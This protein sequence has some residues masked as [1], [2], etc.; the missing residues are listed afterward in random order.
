MKQEARKS[1]RTENE[2]AYLSGRLQCADLIEISLS[3]PLDYEV[4][5]MTLLPMLWLIRYMEKSMSGAI[6]TTHQRS[7]EVE[8]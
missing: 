4:S 1:V 2:K 6:S 8:H 7:E 5:L 3:A